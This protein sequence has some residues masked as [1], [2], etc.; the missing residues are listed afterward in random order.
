MDCFPLTSAAIGTGALT[1]AE[2]QGSPQEEKERKEEV[3]QSSITYQ[4]PYKRKTERE[5]GNLSITED[6]FS[7]VICK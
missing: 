4:W 3:C 2:Q 5:E 6:T 7:D 1:K